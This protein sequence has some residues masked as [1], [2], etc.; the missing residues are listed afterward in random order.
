M[1]LARLVDLA[2]DRLK[3]NIEYDPAALK[4]SVTLRLGADRSGKGEGG[5]RGGLSDEELWSLLN[6]VLAARG[7]TTVRLPGKGGDSAYSVVR[8]ADAPALARVEDGSTQ[9]GP[10][11]GFQT[12]VIRARHRPAK[13]LVEAARL[14][15]SKSAG[16]A[17][18]VGPGG[19]A[20][21]IGASGLIMISDLVP[22][23]EQATRIIDLLDAPGAGAAVEEIPAHNLSAAALAT[24]AGQ[25]A[26][27][28]DAV[29]GEKVPG[30]VLASPSGGSVYLI[31]SADH[32]DY[33]RALIAQLDQ[34]EAVDT[35]TYTPEHF[36]VR[37]VGR[38]IE[39]TVRDAGSAGGAAPGAGGDD[40]WRMVVDELTGALVITATPSQHEKV[41][42]LLDRL[43]SVPA[44][45]R[46]P[47]RSF[48]IKNRPVKEMVGIL[49]ELMKA[50]VLE[51]GAADSGAAAP[52]PGR[53]PTASGITP[54]NEPT[55][56]GAAKADTSPSTPA[57]GAL[58]L[59]SASSPLIP[60]R[61]G[62]AAVSKPATFATTAPESGL[63]LTADEGTNT[64][65][66]VGEPRL[67]S[68]LEQ[69]IKTL[70]VR[71]PQVMLEVVLLSL[72]D[73]Q[74]ISLGVEL[75]K[76]ISLGDN[77]KAN[78]SSLFG[79][80]TAA[81]DGA[82]LVGDA[83]GFTG[84]V[85]SAGEF[86][87]IIRA[88]ETLN[89]GRSLSR[90]RLLVNNNQQAVFSSVL[91]Q[92]VSTISSNSSST[93]SSFG[94][95]QDAGTTA[96]IKPH[97]A[98]G[99]H[100]SLDYEVKLSSFSGASPGAGLPP[101]RQ[102]NR[103]Q[104]S[105][106]IPDNFTV[107]VGGLDVVTDGKGVSQVPFLG[108]IPIIGEAFKSRNNNSSRTTF[109]VFIHATVLRQPSFEDLK[110]ISDLDIAAAAVDDG[111]PVVEPR[112]IR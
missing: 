44:A 98:E 106:T 84:V 91:Q 108:S 55:P 17:G 38:L 50:G 34:R 9:T 32:R 82:R 16:G 39:Q 48:K 75:T 111:W 104:S 58:P 10:A 25:V 94:G 60:G 83:A 78:L 19:A 54:R 49:G 92:P 8:L 37:E 11:G 65:I 53:E 87:A 105:V 74:A 62:V 31:A 21:E 40:R 20:M 80:S 4:G 63:V 95:T 12:I 3:L 7:L 100:L 26:A 1:E 110:Y 103:V 67:L 43:A 18:A 101:P 15:L 89:E 99:D 46:R 2:A 52:A 57:P 70:D 59:P 76:N 88:L 41:K 33:W 93:I 102:E 42:A 71:Q 73:S 35:S 45:A 30:E 85:M 28:R 23:I 61:P 5:A 14:V 81:A 97:I 6:R 56:T 22:R 36:G 90:P 109:Y 96:S 77:T 24:L 72:T 69:L 107:V 66:A 64:L 29:S 13:E 51:A 27:K 68:Q 47:V 86:A 79:L 112:V